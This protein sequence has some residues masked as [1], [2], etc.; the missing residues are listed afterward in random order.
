[1]I[2][3]EDQL[4]FRKEIYEEVIHFINKMGESWME[5]ESNEFGEYHDVACN[6][7][8]AAFRIA[9]DLRKNVD[10]ATVFPFGLYVKEGD[11]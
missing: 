8:N 10:G 2:S 1:M 9:R 3:I 11:K 4:K 7:A 6:Y 5:D